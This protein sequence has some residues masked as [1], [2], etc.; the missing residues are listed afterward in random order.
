G[1]SA[2]L[3]RRQ[4][5]GRHVH[6]QLIGVAGVF[7]AVTTEDRRTF[8]EALP[9]GWWYSAAL[10]ERRAIAVYFTDADLFATARR[11]KERLWDDLLAQTRLTREW[12]AGARRDGPLRVANASSTIAHRI[13][14]AGW[15]AAGDAACTIDPLS[16]QGI[17][18]ALVS[19]IEA[20]E[21]LLAAD[22]D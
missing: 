12:L 16:S 6:D 10:P 21:A 18:W 2:W 17:V 7:Q 9:D 15:L 1:R 8:I 22:P 19:G 4:D 5:A 3:A 20:A 13:T 14:G 11:G